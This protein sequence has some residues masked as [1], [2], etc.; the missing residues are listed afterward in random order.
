MK[1]QGRASFSSLILICVHLC[2]S[3][4][5][6]ALSAAGQRPPRDDADLRYWL[7]NMVW[8][9]RF[10]PDEI[11]AATGLESEEVSAALRRLGIT[12]DDRPPRPPDAPRLVLPYP[13]G[14]HPR[15]GFLDGAV[16][17]QRETKFSV[18][19]PWD[20]DSYVVV[21][22]PEAIFCNLGL[23]YLAH[24]HVPTVWTE[25]GVELEP[26]EWNRREDGS[27]DI[28][29]R[30]PNGIT[31]G[32]KVVP[33]RDAVE[34][35]LWL[36]NGTDQKLTDLRVQN[37]VLLKGAKGFAAQ[38]NDN[39]VLTDPYVAAHSADGRRWVITAWDPCHR[40]WAN[41]DCPCVHSDPKLPDCEPG[42]T[43]RARG[44]L[45][46]YEGEDVQAEFRRIEQTGWRGR[47]R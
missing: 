30:L 20:P 21:D 2:S 11:T 31:F 38:S 47:D 40:P 45:S 19:L 43:V 29:R 39:K 35:E 15:I 18:F 14:R 4:A 6:L 1:R 28:E 46:F 24:T 7:Q 13:G 8:Y 26:L 5:I 3:V 36:T 16:D 34:M 33:S 22:A 27:L 32:V 37:C 23:I 42:D 12:P 44:R 25:Q 41:P 17:P 10:T 9:H